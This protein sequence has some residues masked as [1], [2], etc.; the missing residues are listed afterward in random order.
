MACARCDFYVLK[1]STQGQLIEG[2]NNLLKLR[3]DIPLT[4]TELAAVDGDL[5]AYEKLINQ[6]LDEPAPSNIKKKG[7]LARAL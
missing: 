7:R 6:L 1:K 4:E 2:K 5:S 3:Q